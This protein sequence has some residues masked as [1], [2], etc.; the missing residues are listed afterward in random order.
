[1]RDL[2]QALSRQIDVALRGCLRGLLKGVED[3]Y[4]STT[5]ERV[6]YPV[7]TGTIAKP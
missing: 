5:N 1:L 3:M 7:V 4:R 6:D 2:L